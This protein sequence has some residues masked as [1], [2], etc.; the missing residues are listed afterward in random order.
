MNKSSRHSD[1]QQ[2]FKI[3]SKPRRQ[4]SQANTPGLDST[5]LPIYVPSPV[6]DSQPIH[7][8]IYVAD[9]R[10]N[11]TSFCQIYGKEELPQGGVH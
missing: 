10:C 8:K 2:S 5:A 3:K 6:N 7:E 9:A 4:Q 11:V 1:K